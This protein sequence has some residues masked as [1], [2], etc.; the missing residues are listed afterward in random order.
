MGRLHRTLNKITTLIVY[1]PRA[2]TY[3]VVYG[4]NVLTLPA[5][6]VMLI[7]YYFISMKVTG[8]YMQS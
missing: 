8:K 1:K 7:I 4:E 5:V 2:Y 3:Y 6:Q